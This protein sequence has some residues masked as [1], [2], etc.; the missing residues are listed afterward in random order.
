MLAVLRRF[1]ARAASGGPLSEEPGIA[2]VTLGEDDLESAL[3]RL[4]CLG[5]TA[6]VDLVSDQPVVKSHRHSDAMRWKGRNVALT[7]VYEESDESVRA[8]APDRRTFLLEC[9]DGVTRAIAGYRGGRGPLEHRGLPV[10]DARL[11]A[12]LVAAAETRL[13]LDPFAGAGGVILAAKARG[14]SALSV[15]ADPALRFGLAQLADWHLI[16]DASSLPF[17]SGSLDAVAGEPP[18]DP[19]ALDTVL[20]SIA[21]I[22]RVLR[23]GGRAALVVASA[24]AIEL[25]RAAADAGLTAELDCKVDRKGTDVSCLCWIAAR[26]H[27]LR[28]TLQQ[29][30]Q[31]P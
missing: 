19:S 4:R 28:H 3:P 27:G 30:P 16:G 25:R 13:L 26:P 14:L 17:A 9:A 20:A 31:T 29:D 21:E 6:A 23:P 5:Y 18:Y 1:G 11:L 7:R 15:D 10:E 2:W 12:N 8:S 24:Q 22:A